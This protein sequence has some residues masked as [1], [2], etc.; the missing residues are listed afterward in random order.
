EGHTLNVDGSRDEPLWDAIHEP[1]DRIVPIGDIED[2]A[3][4]KRQIRIEALRVYRGHVDRILARAEW[5]KPE[6]QQ[7]VDIENPHIAIQAHGNP[8]SVAEPGGER[9][10]LTSRVDP[11]NA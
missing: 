7:T 2:S 3:G 11:V 8:S 9:R 10:R 5:A 6:Q 4:R 1:V